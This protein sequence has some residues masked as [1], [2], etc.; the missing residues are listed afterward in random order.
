MDRAAAAFR[1]RRLFPLDAAAV[2]SMAWRGVDGAG[3]QSTAVEGRWQNGRK[4]RVA[5]SALARR[6]C[7]GCWG[8][9]STSSS[10]V[11]PARAAPDARSTVTAGA[12]R[13]AL[14]GGQERR[15]GDAAEERLQSPADAS[16]RRG[17]LA[18]AAARD[19]RLVSQPPETVTRIDLY[20]DHG[21]VGLRRAGGA[22]TFST[23]KVPYAADTRAVDEWLARLGAVKA[24]TRAGGANTR[25]LI[26]EGRFR[27]QAD[28][29]SPAEVHALLAPDP[30]RF[31]ERAVLSFARFDLKR[32]QRGAGKAAQAVTTDDGSS[33]RAR[34]AAP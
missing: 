21:R 4:E 25:H 20:D 15:R 28:V 5:K 23:P 8:Y 27:E 11:R 2:T 9:A 14:R 29:S 31:R 24:A 19:D 10:P 30:L 16:R 13:V 7:G 18:A 6:A 17:A 1:D 33:W 32:L 12:T 3:A 26:V 22:W 34:P